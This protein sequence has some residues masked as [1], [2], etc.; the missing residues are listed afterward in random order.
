MVPDS[1]KADLWDLKAKAERPPDFRTTNKPPSPSLW[2]QANTP[3]IPHI[4]NAA[5]AIAD[6][7]DAPKLDRSETETAIRGFLAGAT[8]GA[9][10]LLGSF[11]SPIGLALTAAG[12]GPESRL[13]KTVPGFKAALEL[14][15]VRT[16]QRLVRTSGGAAFA[17]HRAER[18]VTAPTWTE[19]AQGIGEMAAGGLGI[20]P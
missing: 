8:T 7:L 6:Y 14:P 11:T 20:A 10:D 15:A 17:G 1:V 9:G 4:A 2:E 19:K 13:V 12:F 5:H 3:L 16:L 18:V